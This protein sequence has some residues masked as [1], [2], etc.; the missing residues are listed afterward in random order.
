MTTYVIGDITRIRFAV[1]EMID[2]ISTEMSNKHE[3]LQAGI[4]LPENLEIDAASDEEYSDY[5][6]NCE[7]VWF[8]DDECSNESD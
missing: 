5:E 8:S 1:T 2:K 3:V 6:D 4:V 7:G